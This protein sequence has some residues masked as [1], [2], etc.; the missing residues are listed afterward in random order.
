MLDTIVNLAIS[1]H[2][3]SVLVQNIHH[4]AIQVEAFHRIV[5]SL[6]RRTDNPYFT[7]ATT[8]VCTTHFEI[9]I[10]R[11]GQENNIALLD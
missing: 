7:R 11:V 1:P 2:P 10:L 6:N 3:R 9:R 8:K 4:V 5:I